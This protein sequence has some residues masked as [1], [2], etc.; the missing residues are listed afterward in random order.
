MVNVGAVANYLPMNDLERRALFNLGIDRYVTTLIMPITGDSAQIRVEIRSV[1]SP[2][3]DTLVDAEQIE[4]PVGMFATTTIEE[5]F[6]RALLQAAEPLFTR[7]SER[8]R[9][10]YEHK[11]AGTVSAGDGR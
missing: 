2:T 4:V 11:S 7:E 10:A 1:V 8:I 3:R 9:A 5:D 6:V